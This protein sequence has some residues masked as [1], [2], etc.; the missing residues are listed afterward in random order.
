MKALTFLL[1]FFLIIISPHSESA[2]SSQGSSKERLAVLIQSC[3]IFQEAKSCFEKS[4]GILGAASCSNQWEEPSREARNQLIQ[5]NFIS[6]EEYDMSRA[7]YN[8]KRQACKNKAKSEGFWFFEEKLI[9]YKCFRPVAL[10]YMDSIIT[11]FNC[12]SIPS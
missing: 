1:S 5:Y 8:E 11:R 9:E 2:S 7:L 12:A 3:A 6:Q 10:D 4:K